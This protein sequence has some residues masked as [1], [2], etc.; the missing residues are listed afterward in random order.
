MCSTVHRSVRRRT[1]EWRQTES[2]DCRKAFSWLLASSKAVSGP[3]RRPMV[4]SCAWDH[5]GTEK[6]NPELPW[7]TSLAHMCQ[8]L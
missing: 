6:M 5:C 1:A 3:V 8:A 2:K 4:I 7:E